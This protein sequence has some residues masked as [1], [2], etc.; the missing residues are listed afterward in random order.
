MREVV[1]NWTKWR[2]RDLKASG[3]MLSIS[4]EASVCVSVT[5]MPSQTGSELTWL[6]IASK[7]V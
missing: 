4:L 7:K 2:T 3:K 6:S 1:K 5:L